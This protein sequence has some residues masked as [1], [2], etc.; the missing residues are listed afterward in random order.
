MRKKRDKGIKDAQKK[1]TQG[2]DTESLQRKDTPFNCCD[3]LF[4]G[5]LL[6]FFIRKKGIQI[7]TMNG[8]K[9]AEKKHTLIKNYKLKIIKG[10]QKKISAC[11][12]TFLRVFYLFIV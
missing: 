1:D 2:R 10:I 7:A 5:S 3:H 11:L 9:F 4:F 8:I 6:V 12:E